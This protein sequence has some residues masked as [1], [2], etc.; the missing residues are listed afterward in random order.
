MK[1]KSVLLFV[2]LFAVGC[3]K[4]DI[5]YPN[6]QALITEIEFKGQ[7]AITIDNEKMTINVTLSDGIDITNVEM[8]KF[9]TTENTT[10]VP[11][12]ESLPYTIDLSSE[13]TFILTNYRDYTW[14][15]IATVDSNIGADVESQVGKSIFNVTDKSVQIFVSEDSDLKN[16]KVNSISFS[17]SESVVVSPNPAT[18]KD[19]SSPVEFRVTQFD[20][21]NVWTVTMA[22]K[23]ISTNNPDEVWA[24]KAVLSANI[25]KGRP[26]VGFEYKKVSDSQ[27]QKVSN[28]IFDE[29]KITATIL[30]E[31]ETKYQ[32]RVYQGTIYGSDMTF[33]TDAMPVLN[34][35]S[36]ENWYKKDKTWFPC[37]ESEYG[38][39]GAY[40]GYWNSGNSGVTIF[41]DSN[42]YPTDDAIKGKAACLETIGN[43]PLVGMA[44]GSLFV[45]NFITDLFK[46]LNSPKFGHPFTGRPTKLIGKYKYTPTTIT[47]SDEKKTPEMIKYKGELDRCIIWVNLEDWGGAT[48]RPA[49]PTIIARAVFQ[50]YGVVSEYKDFEAIFDYKIKDRKP[51]HICLVVSASEFGDFY[52][53]GVGTKLFV[54]E[55]SLVY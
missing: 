36:F 25:V 21:T 33:T 8:T 13:K 32:Y 34:N 28:V 46:P 11:A 22:K 50:E 18:V 23:S 54:D 40:K 51:T 31:P 55:F 4:N 29:G 52:T 37:L 47:I 10:V 5:P 35:G 15:I 12:I 1:L 39:D 2:I 14:K 9:V 3:I 49:N 27:Y 6:I 30:T 38:K 19:F 42:V 20:V 24:R 53:G 45:G 17:S 16:I 48:S 41:K 44:A 26:D 43:M 7:E